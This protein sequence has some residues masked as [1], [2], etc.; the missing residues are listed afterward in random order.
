MAV[1][2]SMLALSDDAQ[3]HT[4]TAHPW[5]DLGLENPLAGLAT[6][7]LPRHI[8]AHDIDTV[9]RDKSLQ[10]RWVGSCDALVDVCTQILPNDMACCFAEMLEDYNTFMNPAIMRLRIEA[11]TGKSCWKWHRDYTTL[12]LI[13]TLRG[14]GTQYLKD[15]NAQ[16]HVETIP[17]GNFG[18]FKGR[19]FGAGHHAAV[20]RSPAP[21]SDWSVRLVIVIDTPNS[22]EL[23]VEKT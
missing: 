12:R 23:E 19:L 10:G 20:H 14:P 11:V 7:P 13:C 5:H 21:S 3:S 17:G 15:P 1:S 9:L 22:H 6:A 16:D 2:S 18:L 4:Q 8:S